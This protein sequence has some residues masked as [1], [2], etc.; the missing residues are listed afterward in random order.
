LSVDRELVKQ[1][2]SIQRK[3][4]YVEMNLEKSRQQLEKVLKDGEPPNAGRLETEKYHR[5]RVQQQEDNLRQLRAE[6]ERLQRALA[7]QANADRAAKKAAMDG[8]G[9]ATHYQ[10]SHR[11][12]ARGRETVGDREEGSSRS[13]STDRSGERRRQ[14]EKR[15][16]DAQLRLQLEQ[17]RTRRAKLAAK[18]R[19][20]VARRRQQQQRLRAVQNTGRNLAIASKRQKLA[21]GKT[22]GRRYSERQQAAMQDTAPVP[23]SKTDKVVAIVGM[24]VG[25]V[26]FFWLLGAFRKSK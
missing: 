18:E 7:D 11:S 17:E 3:I 20:A 12:E 16:A 15:A 5:L 8:F 4:P 9:D 2:K 23:W 6:Q 13:E 25:V 1:L 10:S 14:A 26:G 21:Q 19:K 22:G 24:G